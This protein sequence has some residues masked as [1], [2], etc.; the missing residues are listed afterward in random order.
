MYSCWRG[1]AEVYTLTVQ[2]LENDSD[3]D[4]DGDGE[5]IDAPRIIEC[6]FI[7]AVL[8]GCRAVVEDVLTL[9]MSH[10][11]CDVDAQICVVL[12]TVL[13]RISRS[14]RVSLSIAACDARLLADVCRYVSAH[15]S[16]RA[17]CYLCSCRRSAFIAPTCLCLAI[18]CDPWGVLV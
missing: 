9:R 6:I 1:W 2:E 16:Q 12:M 11:C 13:L 14:V 3:S 8:T 10:L 4:G 5:E 18:C 17:D 15:L 7:I